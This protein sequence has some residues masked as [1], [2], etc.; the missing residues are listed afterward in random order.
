MTK[1]D[2]QAEVAPVEE[3]TDILM[4]VGYSN[5]PTIDD[6]VREAR[7]QGVCKRINKLP[8]H[9]KAGASRLFLAHDEGVTGDGVI[10]GYATLDGYEVLVGENMTPGQKERVKALKEAG[11]KEVQISD[12]GSEPSRGCGRRSEP[13]ALYLRATLRVFQKPVDYNATIH[14]DAKR[15]RGVKKVDGEALVAKDAPRKEKPSKRQPNYTGLSKVASKAKWT[16]EEEQA[17]ID[18]VVKKGMTLAEAVKVMHRETGRSELGI[19]YKL[20]HG[21]NSLR[22]R[23]DE[24]LHKAG[25]VLTTA[26]PGPVCLDEDDD[27]DEDD[28]DIETID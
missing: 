11:A 6:F 28:G 17:M 8:A 5:Y 22:V 1:K 25:K 16:P 20:Y 24:A 21:E 4:W 10:F 7:T 19:N 9:L 2:Q 13:G 12:L 14:V 26:K 23:I 15:F 3:P 27:E 18:L